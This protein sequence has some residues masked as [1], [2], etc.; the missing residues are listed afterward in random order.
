MGVVRL[1]GVVLNP[2]GTQITN[3]VRPIPSM[4]A[5]F[6]DVGGDGELLKSAA[7]RNPTI[8]FDIWL[9][10]TTST[11]RRDQIRELSKKLA[12]KKARSLKFSDDGTKYYWVVR[13]GDIVPQEF[14]DSAVMHVRLKS[15]YP[16]MVDEYQ[17][18]SSDEAFVPDGNYPGAIELRSPADITVDSNNQFAFGGLTFTLEDTAYRRLTEFNSE[19]RI[20]QFNGVNFAPYATN[21]WPTLTPG[22]SRTIS[23]TKGS[24]S[25][26][27]R[28]QPRWI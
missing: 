3:V 16:W 8:E 5:S 21:A 4:D 13:D 18:F 14:I 17:Y 19:K 11:E 22:S 25:L 2:S 28:Y 23:V 6:V 10:G 1:N 20:A 15:I 26:Q 12:I 9:L 7:L 24:A 27:F